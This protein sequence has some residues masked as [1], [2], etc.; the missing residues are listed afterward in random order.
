VNAANS[1]FHRS[2]GPDSTG[3]LSIPPRTLC[4]TWSAGCNQATSSRIT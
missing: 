3:T 1:T 2:A 4:W